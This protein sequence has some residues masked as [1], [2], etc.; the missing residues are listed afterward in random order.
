MHRAN[1]KAMPRDTL[2]V[3]VMSLNESVCVRQLDMNQIH[4]FT[5]RRAARFCRWGAHGIAAPGT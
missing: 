1:G 2:M 4:D 5:L 3:P